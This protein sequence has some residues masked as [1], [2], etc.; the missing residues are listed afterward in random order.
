[1]SG[2]Q[3]D[4]FPFLEKGSVALYVGENGLHPEV[5]FKTEPIPEDYMKEYINDDKW[6]HIAVVVKDSELPNLHD[7]IVLYL[8][9]EVAIIDDIGLLDLLPVETA[10]KDDVRIGGGY[11]GLIDE[12][13]IY[14]RALVIDEIK[15]IQ[16]GRSN[17]PLA[18]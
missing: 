9:G 1:M 7:D 14:S 13:R 6:H 18:K 17:R 3:I 11:I 12:V 4:Y 10:K 2:T 16:Q 15:A 5:S 8:D